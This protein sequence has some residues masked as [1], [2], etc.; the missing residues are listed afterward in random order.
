MQQLKRMARFRLQTLLLAVTAV[1]FACWWIVWP[2]ATAERFVS[3][4]ASTAEPDAEFLNVAAPND[5]LAEFHKM[6]HRNPASVRLEYHDRSAGDILFGRRT[7]VA[8]GEQ[9]RY[10]FWVARGKI[11]SGPSP[12]FIYGGVELMLDVF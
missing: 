12:A 4:C 11:V 6:V 1:A 5:Y 9:G 7:C 10:R 2:G 3:R 8:T